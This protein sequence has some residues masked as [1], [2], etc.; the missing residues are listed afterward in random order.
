MKI[1]LR[2]ICLIKSNS[3]MWHFNMDKKMKSLMEICLYNLN[4][5]SG[6]QGKLL[7]QPLIIQ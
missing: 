7:V 2:N 3:K 5:I 1:T 4:N 6:P